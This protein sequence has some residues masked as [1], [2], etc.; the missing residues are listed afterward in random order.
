MLNITRVYNA[1][2]AVANMRR[3]IALCRDYSDRRSAFGKKL[4]ELP[5]QVKTLFDMEIRFRANFLFLMKVTQWMNE[6]KVAKNTDSSKLFRMSTSL[7]KLFTGKESLAV[8]SEGIEFIGGVGYMENSNLPTLLR[9]CQVLT[10]WEGTTNVLSLDFAR[11]VKNGDLEA[12]W[13]YF[14]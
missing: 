1:T 10:I 8:V 7:L 4:N 9:D 13:R 14:T 3:I 11:S 5:L 12:Y 2:T 6:A